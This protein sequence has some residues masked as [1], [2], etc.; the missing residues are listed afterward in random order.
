MKKK[1]I[2]RTPKKKR[3]A[4][5]FFNAIKILNSRHRSTLYF[6]VALKLKNLK[7]C[8]FYDHIPNNMLIYEI[9]CKCKCNICKWFFQVFS[10]IQNGHSRIDFIFAVDL[11]LLSSYYTIK[12][13]YNRAYVLRWPVLLCFAWSPWISLTL[14]IPF[15]DRVREF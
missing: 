10:E 14:S 1:K 7:L 9:I 2:N 6:F 5:D 4:N 12:I 3:S 15:P 13:V 8:K 11:L